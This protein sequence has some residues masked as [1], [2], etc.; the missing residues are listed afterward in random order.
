MEDTM[1]DLAICTLA[2]IM[3][4]DIIRQWRFN[5]R[6]ACAVDDLEGELYDAK[7]DLR[8]L[9]DGGDQ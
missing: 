7:L 9:A 1:S 4:I 8:Q 3:A 6:L 2:L 5:A